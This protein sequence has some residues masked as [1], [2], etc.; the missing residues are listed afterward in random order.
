MTVGD[1]I[2]A[3][4]TPVLVPLGYILDERSADGATFKSPLSA[5]VA[6]YVP[7]DGELTVYVEPMDG[8]ER[9]QLLLYLR[10]IRSEAARQ[11]GEAVAESEDEAAKQAGIFA[12]GL[13]DA[14]PLLIGDA[15]A[16]R[17]ARDLRWW[18]ANQPADLT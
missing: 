18:N 2:E 8:G 9:I 12:A 10:A 5:V 11:L 17:D 1:A 15:S 16:V 7:R 6:R 4:F 14:G 3:A 13:R